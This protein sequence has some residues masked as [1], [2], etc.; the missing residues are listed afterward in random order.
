MTPGPSIASSAPWL[1]SNAALHDSSFDLSLPLFLSLLSSGQTAPA[2]RLLVE[3]KQRRSRLEKVKADAHANSAHKTSADNADANSM[4][5]KHLA[6]LKIDDENTDVHSALPL[7]APSRAAQSLVR[8]A[9]TFSRAATDN[10][11][12]AANKSI[13]A[14]GASSAAATQLNPID[15]FALQSINRHI[16]SHRCEISE[17]CSSNANQLLQCHTRIIEL[18]HSNSIDELRDS[19]ADVADSNGELCLLMRDEHQSE[20]EENQLKVRIELMRHTIL[21]TKQFIQQIQT[22]REDIDEEAKRVQQLQQNVRLSNSQSTTKSKHRKGSITQLPLGMASSDF[23][24]LLSRIDKLSRQTAQQSNS[25]I[26]HHLQQCID[27]VQRHTLAALQCWSDALADGM[28]MRLGRIAIQR[29]QLMAARHWRQGEKRIALLARNKLQLRV[30]DEDEEPNEDL[31]DSD[32]DSIDESH[33]DH[34]IASA[35]ESFDAASFLSAL[36][37]TAQPLVHSIQ[38]HAHYNKIPKLATA[39]KLTRIEPQIK[40]IREVMN[41]LSQPQST[42]QELTS[43]L[44]TLCGFA[45]I[46]SHC[47]RLIGIASNLLPMRRIELDSLFERQCVPLVRSSCVTALRS[48]KSVKESSANMRLIQSALTLLQHRFAFQQA[49]SILQ[50]CTMESATHYTALLSHELR[51]Q[52]ERLLL[53]ERWTALVIKDRVSYESTVVEFCLEPP[54][55]MPVSQLTFPHTCTFSSSIASLAP[56]LKQTMNRLVRYCLMLPPAILTRTFSLQFNSL[57]VDTVCAS[58]SDHL[59]TFP[60]AQLH[61]SLAVQWSINAE[62]LRNLTAHFERHARNSI[63]IHSESEAELE[64]S[65]SASRLSRGGQSRPHS[66]NVSTMPSSSVLSSS[67]VNGQTV[68]VNLSSASTAFSSLRLRCED[69]MVELLKAKIESMLQL[70]MDWLPQ[71]VPGISAAA[72]STRVIPISSDTIG[73][74]DAVQSLTDYLMSLFDCMSSLPLQVRESIYFS[75]CKHIAQTVLQQWTAQPKFNMIALLQLHSDCKRLVKFTLQLSTV[76]LSDCFA[77]LRQLCDIFLHSSSI[78]WVLDPAQRSARANYV[79]QSNLHHLLVAFRDLPPKM[80]LSSLELQGIQLQR[81][82]TEQCAKKL[83]KQF[84]A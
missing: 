39:Y 66:R 57:L 4:P 74:S 71:S 80:S 28:Q 59:D 53:S 77:E 17:F 75:C 35:S 1:S 42:M 67:S 31:T 78:D 73:V 65:K 79:R 8:R 13:A 14:A 72:S 33:P 25:A 68:A 47:C 48:C 49:S 83:E 50:S 52:F 45:I 12:A 81:K 15:E 11:L 69:L 29:Q 2:L 63:L 30:E 16:E 84:K 51:I 55:A 36:H 76:G 20:H 37:I 64:R 34:Q 5:H 27:S 82:Q 19:S 41:A 56:L 54:D 22:I 9:S 6:S 38:V 46:E 62:V 43:A 10:T 32:S 26:S 60:S 21:Q 23:A 18:Q 70:H 7:G 24:S 3:A 40:T 44:S 61:I 58:L